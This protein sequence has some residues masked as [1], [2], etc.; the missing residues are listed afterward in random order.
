MIFTKLKSDHYIFKTCKLLNLN[1]NVYQTESESGKELIFW[2]HGDGI[3]SLHSNP[4]TYS[5]S[6]YRAELKKQIFGSQAMKNRLSAV[7]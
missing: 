2:V 5:E 1:D 3:L 4:E 6:P 7:N